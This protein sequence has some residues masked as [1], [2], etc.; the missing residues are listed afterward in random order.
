MH[1]WT[2]IVNGNIE[3]K[4]ATIC[5]MCL[6]LTP[7]NSNEVKNKFKKHM[8]KAHSATCPMEKLA[9]MCAEAEE[10][11]EREGLNLNDIIE[12]ERER[13]EAAMRKRAESGGLM[14]MFRRKQEVTE[15]EIQDIIHL[16]C[17]LCQGT[18]TGSK[19]DELEKHLDKDH[20]VI[21]GI[22]EITDLSEN[23]KDEVEVVTDE[24]AATAGD[25]DCQ[26][27]DNLLADPAPSEMRFDRETG[28]RSAS[29]IRKY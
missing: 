4:Q 9:E 12:E 5:F 20:K 3:E 25:D 1:P 13:Q 22:K 8:T 27:E 7:L 10:K 24:V 11:E 19:K 23:Q 21:F 14:R 18:W 26:E 15:P 29:S 28:E 2:K 6:Q 17:F 16:E